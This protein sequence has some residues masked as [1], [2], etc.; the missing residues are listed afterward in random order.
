MTDCVTACF[1]GVLMSATFCDVGI[2]NADGKCPGGLPPTNIELRV[3][4]GTTDLKV[5]PI[6]DRLLV[7]ER[8]GKEVFSVTIPP[9]ISRWELEQLVRATGWWQDPSRP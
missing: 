3:L 7:F 1:V 6:I 2:P 5:L 4:D 8:N 9:E